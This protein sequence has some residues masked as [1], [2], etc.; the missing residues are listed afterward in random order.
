MFHSVGLESHP[1]VWSYISESIE[2]FEAKI[3]LFKKRGFSGIFWDD[4]FEY[5][6]GRRDLPDNS[7]LLTFD[8]G[9][10]DNWVHV[11]PILRKYGMKGTIFVSP[12]F[13]DPIS[14]VRPNLDD[15]AA[16]RCRPHE[17]IVA[18][19]LNWAEMREM[20]RS[21]FI[22]IQS[23]AMTHTWYFGGPRIVAFHEPQEVKPLPWLFWNA[24]PDRKP[25]YLTED[26]QEFLP[27]GY[28]I[29]EHEKSLTVRQFFP[30][31]NAVH[32]ITSFV[33]A[34]GAR[35][36]FQR[37]DWRQVLE[38]RVANTFE[39]GK[40]PGTYETDESRVTRITDELQRSKTLIESNLEKQVDYICWPG[41]ANDESVQAIARTVGY[42]SW[43]LSSRSEL[44]KRNRRGEDPSSIKRIGTSNQII[45]K[46]RRCGTGGPYYQ[47]WRAM[48]H[49]GSPLHSFAVKAYKSYALISHFGGSK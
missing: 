41:G 23:H 44:G 37:P 19:F 9:Y 47:I 3:A 1:W 34:H 4:L 27:W 29:L 17:L 2:S 40:L 49:Q 8:D 7:I 10:L 25:F 20:E 35:H 36:F 12:D 26:Q 6:A 22:D 33:T 32:E 11:Y 42:K 39:C 43:T 38:N 5:M 45:V 14:E 31:E 13:V 21:G 30:D 16:G 18:G 15:V 28:P 24:R 46:G 48:A